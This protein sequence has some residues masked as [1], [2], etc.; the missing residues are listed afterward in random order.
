MNDYDYEFDPTDPPFGY[1]GPHAAMAPMYIGHVVPADWPARADQATHEVWAKLPSWHIQEAACLVCDLRPR[2]T[3]DLPLFPMD[4]EPN[5]PP[6]YEGAKTWNALFRGEIGAVLDL[7]ARF[8]RMALSELPPDARYLAP[9]EFVRFCDEYGIEVPT[10][11]RDAVNRR[12]V[13]N[14]APETNERKSRYRARAIQ[15]AHDLEPCGVR[16]TIQM[17]QGFIESDIAA[18]ERV[19]ARTIQDYL[20]EW[21][22]DEGNADGLRDALRQLL[23]GRGR[24]SEDEKDQLRRRLPDNYTRMI[25][26]S[27]TTTRKTK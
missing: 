5:A 11:L 14:R 18:D 13:A 12:V 24:L 21:R 2:K 6:P 10:G 20:K 17:F 15:V 8:K 7:F 26:A 22:G 1:L 25:P 16:V 9:P 4:S 19:D 27:G 3:S 23:R